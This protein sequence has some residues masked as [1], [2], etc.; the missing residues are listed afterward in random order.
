MINNFS[1]WL[2]NKGYSVPQK[3]RK[4]INDF[5]NQISLKRWQSIPL[6]EMSEFLAKFGLKI[7]EAILTGRD[8]RANLELLTMEDLPVN[9][10]LVLQ[11][12]K[13]EVT[14]DFEI[15]AYLS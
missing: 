5:L 12:H 4:V 2:E 9:S 15:T 10:W 8:G 3:D 1:K 14:P 6:K 13:G 11:W 7:E